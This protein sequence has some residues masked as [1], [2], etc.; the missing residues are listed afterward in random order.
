MNLVID[1][2]NTRTKLSLFNHGEEMISVPVEELRPEHLSLLIDEHPEL[3]RAILSAVKEYDPNL[4]IFLRDHFR[5]FIELDS[6]TPLPFLNQYLSP[7]TLGRDRLAAVAGAVT[8]YPQM[9][10]LVVDAGTAIT[11]DIVNEKMQYLGGNISPG[12]RMRFEALHRLTGR[13]PLVQPS[14]SIQLFGNRT[15]EAI[16]QGIQNGI[17]YEVDGSIDRFKEIYTN[18]IVIITGGDANFFEKRLKNSFFVHFNL[19]AIGLNR[20][21]EH[22]GDK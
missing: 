21:L 10:V 2:G 4:K 12:L 22:N 16:R 13:L 14:D 7:E 9:P 18:L 20:I 1:I 11:F 6:D 5:S 15:E 19:V 8:L 3:D 17:L